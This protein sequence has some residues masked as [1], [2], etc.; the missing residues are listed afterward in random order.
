MKSS[1]HVAE[2]AFHLGKLFALFGSHLHVS[3]NLFVESVE[4]IVDGFE[5]LAMIFYL[6][7]QFLE[8]RVVYTLVVLMCGPG[9]V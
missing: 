6:I 7:L 5:F 1:V 4:T 9:N 8:F 3:E 2:L